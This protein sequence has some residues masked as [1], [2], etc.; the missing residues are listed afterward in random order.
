MDIFGG[1]FY[2]DPQDSNLARNFIKRM[3]ISTLNFMCTKGLKKSLSNNFVEGILKMH[4]FV[5]VIC[6]NIK[7]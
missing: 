3:I 5:Q 4:L 1:I 6:I 7:K 2:L